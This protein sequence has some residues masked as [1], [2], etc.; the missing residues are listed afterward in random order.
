MR[1]LWRSLGEDGQE[2]KVR[3][4]AQTCTDG[5]VLYGHGRPKKVS[6][7]TKE[8]V[9]VMCKNRAWYGQEVRTIVRTNKKVYR[10]DLKWC[11]EILGRKRS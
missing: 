10:I 6:G 5:T 7:S 1:R 9:W 4:T 8:E 3:A 2:C 11:W